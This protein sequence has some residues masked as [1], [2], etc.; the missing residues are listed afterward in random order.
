[1]QRRMAENP[2]TP[3]VQSLSR[4]TQEAVIAAKG[5]SS[6]DT[7]TR[8]TF[9]FFLFYYISKI[10]KILFLLYHYGGLSVEKNE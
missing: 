9:D 10:S 2:Q 1:M 3:G 5:T 6:L 8:V 7:Y 4:H